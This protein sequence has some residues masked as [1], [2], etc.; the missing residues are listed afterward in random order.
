MIDLS[1]I[2]KLMH[3]P[4]RNYIIPGLTSW[5]IGE[6]STCGK[7]RVFTCER[8]HQE[9]IAPHSHRY[10]FQCMVLQGQVDNIIWNESIL[11]DEYCVTE[12]I[13]KDEI[14]NY[15]K[16]DRTVKRY[17][18]HSRKYNTTECYY[19]QSNQI[20]SISFSKGTVVLFFEG[21]CLS[22][23]ATH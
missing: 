20:H 17:Q 7:V 13:Y 6:P 8:D 18:C 10:D 4:V 2:E 14:G 22:S 5:L 3:S 21:R 23:L 15:E 12:M 16:S 19:M 11:G 9:Q 1:H